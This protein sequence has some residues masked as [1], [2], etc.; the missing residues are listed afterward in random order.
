MAGALQSCSVAPKR[1]RHINL[2]FLLWRGSGGPRDNRPAKGTKKVYVFSSETRKSISS[3]LPAGCPRVNRLFK[4]LCVKSLCAFL[5]PELVQTR[6]FRQIWE[7]LVQVNF[8]GN[9]YGPM[10]PSPYFQGNSYGPM[11][12]KVR[13]SFHWDCYWSMDGSSQYI[14]NSETLH[15]ILSDFQEHK[16]ENHCCGVNQF[17][18]RLRRLYPDQFPV[19][20]RC[21]FILW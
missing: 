3:G 15:V 1:K 14:N 18:V 7:P 11:A 13:L 2:N 12:R 9:S 6:T 19:W 20:C 16:L 21:D 8:R 4:I 17:K 10:V 5:L